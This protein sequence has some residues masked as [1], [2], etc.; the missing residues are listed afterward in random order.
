MFLLIFFLLLKRV[1][2]ALECGVKEVVSK[3]SCLRLCLNVKEVPPS[4][5]FLSLHSGAGAEQGDGAASGALLGV[6]AQDRRRA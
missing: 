4:Y 3:V 5:S 6:Q 2:F 1:D